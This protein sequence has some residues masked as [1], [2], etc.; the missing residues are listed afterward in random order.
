MVSLKC[1]RS[2]IF[3]YQQDENFFSLSLNIAILRGS[4]F[5]VKA[6]YSGHRGSVSFVLSN[7][8]SGPN[9]FP[10]LPAFQGTVMSAGAWKTLF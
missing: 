4:I 1:K 2:L 3:G 10:G 7:I 6:A 8:A 5:S 9:L